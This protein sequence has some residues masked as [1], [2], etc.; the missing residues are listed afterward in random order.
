M[1]YQQ[2]HKRRNSGVC[3]MVGFFN[4]IPTAQDSTAVFSEYH[5]SFNEIPT[6]AQRVASFFNDLPTTA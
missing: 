2:G 5:S 3:G 6:T 1:T 4:D